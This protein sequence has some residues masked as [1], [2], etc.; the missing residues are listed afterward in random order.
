MIQK[1]PNENHNHTLDLTPTPPCRLTLNDYIVPPN[2][3]L[4]SNLLILSN[5]LQHN[6]MNNY[7]LNMLSSNPTNVDTNVCPANCLNVCPQVTINDINIS[8]PTSASHP[9]INHSSSSRVA[10]IDSQPTNTIT[11]TNS[12]TKCPSSKPYS[13]QVNHR[14]PQLKLVFG[15]QEVYATS[16]TSFNHLFTVN[17]L[18]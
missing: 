11:L 10:V 13:L 5:C 14:Q 4:N 8:K 2:T 7:N 9:I 18:M 17:A 16:S 1:I 12:T 3:H 6:H 15:M